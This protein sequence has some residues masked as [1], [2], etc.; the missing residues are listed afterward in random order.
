MDAAIAP[1]EL[2]QR[3]AAFPPPTLVDYLPADAVVALHGDAHAA[4]QRFFEDAES[5]YRPLRGDKARPLLPPR[6]E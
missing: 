3:L 6:V 4:A 1:L 2:K 5:R